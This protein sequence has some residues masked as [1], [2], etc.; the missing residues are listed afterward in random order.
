MDISNLLTDDAILSETGKRIA[1]YRIEQQLTQAVLAEQAGVSKRTVE[2]LEAGASVVMSTF[3]RIL[4]VLDLL[5]ELDRLIP[6]PG[7]GPMELLKLKG[8]GRQRVS[9]ICQN[10]K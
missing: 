5:P 7:P 6:F 3:I 8:R 9:S 1:R 10:V 2:R 4:R